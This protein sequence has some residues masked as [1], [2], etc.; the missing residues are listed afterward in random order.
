MTDTLVDLDLEYLE[1]QGPPA[2]ES[3][4][5]RSIGLGEHRAH[6]WAH[7]PCGSIDAMCARRRDE[8]NDSGWWLCVGTSGCGQKHYVDQIDWTPITGG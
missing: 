3:T 5:H 7:N 4:K 2:C 6:Y 1:L 8:L